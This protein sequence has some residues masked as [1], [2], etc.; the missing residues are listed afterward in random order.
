VSGPLDGLI[1]ENAAELY[2]KVLAAGRLRLA[3]DPELEDSAA[4]RELTE[5]GFVRKRYVGEPVVV[6]VDPA[7]AVENALL[8]AQRQ[9]LEQHKMVV[10]VRDQMAMLQRLY[11]AGGAESAETVPSIQV[12]SDPAEIGALSV[13]L[14]LSAERDVSNL[15]TPHFQRAPDP[16]SVK[17]PP[18]D[19]L[20][21]GVQFR[22]IYARAVLDLP[23]AG[24]MVRRCREGGWQQRVVPDLPL[25]MVLVDERAALLP[26]DA[27]GMEG[28]A[29]VRAPVIVSMLRSYFE[30]LWNRSVPLDGP[31]SGRLTEAADQVLRLMLTGM[32]DAAISRH[33]GTSE[34]TVRRHVAAVLETFG[35]DNR[36]TA[37][38]VAIREGWID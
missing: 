10:R 4:L 27:T 1:P 37:A 14:C 28:A 31:N 6:P 8:T 11:V 9:I 25:K 19:V 33:L 22:N 12:L 17:L 29:L 24:E 5:R 2:Q 32:T 15:E 38:V 35:V 18:A 23:G 26:L 3:D 30:M 20:A 16:R 13:E 21:R 36:I 34:R 7:R